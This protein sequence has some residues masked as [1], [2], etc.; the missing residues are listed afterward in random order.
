MEARTLSNNIDL[1]SVC[2]YLLYSVY[3]HALHIV[4]QINILVRVYV[5][6]P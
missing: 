3:V 2:S 6:L 1:V 5:Y 4:Q